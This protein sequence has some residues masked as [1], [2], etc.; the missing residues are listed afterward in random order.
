MGSKIC[1]HLHKR[2]SIL[3][4]SL[5]WP[6]TDLLRQLVLIAWWSLLSVCTL[7]TISIQRLDAFRAEQRNAPYISEQNL[8]GVEPGCL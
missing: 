5:Q 4:A 6:Q 7:C 8:S 3:H 2:R 1:F